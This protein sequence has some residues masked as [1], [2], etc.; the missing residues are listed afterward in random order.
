MNILSFY[1]YTHTHVHNQARKTGGNIKNLSIRIIYKANVCP[2]QH[3]IIINPLFLICKRSIY[4]YLLLFYSVQSHVCKYPLEKGLYILCLLHM[5]RTQTIQM[6]KRERNR[7]KNHLQS[8]LISHYHDNSIPFSFYIHIYNIYFL[9]II[10]IRIK[11]KNTCGGSGPYVEW[12]PPN[13]SSSV[14]MINFCYILH[15]F[16]YNN[17]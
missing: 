11:I 4:L 3:L 9:S 15:T 16:H 14:M 6:R 2:C 12:K 10:R 8:N 7:L 1:T 5:L 17:I 13:I